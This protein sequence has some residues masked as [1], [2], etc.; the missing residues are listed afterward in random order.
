MLSYLTDLAPIWQWP[1]RPYAVGV[2]TEIRT[3]SQEEWLRVSAHLGQNRYSLGVRAAGQYPDAA[4]LAG[5]PLLTAPGWRLTGPI[6]LSRIRI[7]FRPQAP[8]PAG[9]DVAALA[10]LALPSRADGSRYRRYSDVIGELAAPAIFENRPVYRLL[11][12]DLAAGDPRLVFGRGRFFDGVNAGGVAGF[13]YAA[14][15]LGLVGRCAYRDAVGDPTN[16]DVRSA[17]M[18]TCAL[19]LRYDRAAG[20]AMFPMHYRDPA[21]VGHAGG[22]YQ[23]IPVGIFQPSGEAEW[24]EANDFD[25]WRG[26][27]REYA[28]ELL[29]GSEEYGSEDAPVDYACW[30]LARAMTDALGSG[31]IRAYCLGLGTDPLTYATDLLAV[32]VID[33]PL[34][35]E[36]FGALVSDNAEGLVLAPRPFDEPAVKELLTRAPLQA[37]GSALLTLALAHRDALLH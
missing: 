13:E 17:A 32:V 10:P 14:A 26:L 34:Y 33:A 20:T 5:T 9:P 8:R 11:A 36:L 15:D 3:P 2:A 31:E 28:E 24:N 1:H 7:E 29:G 19:T 16:L 4:R 37:A 21:L 27:L 22:L 18:A 6:P 12:A 23:V 25:L 35:D 30:P